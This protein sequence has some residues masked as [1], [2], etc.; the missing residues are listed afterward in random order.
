MCGLLLAA[1]CS[2][3]RPAAAV[4]NAAPEARE[5]AKKDERRGRPLP[6]FDGASLGGDS[7]SLSAMLGRRLLIFGYNPE[8]PEAAQA[9][10]AL[11]AVAGERADHNFEIVG[12]A[13]GVPAEA[14]RAFLAEHKLEIESFHDEPGALMRQLGFRR[15]RYLLLVDAD[16]NML[17]G[18]D[19]FSESAAD[20]AGEIETWA[21]ESLRLP[22][23]NLLEGEKPLA[24][25]FTAPRLRSDE[26]FSLAEHRGK[27][28]LLLTFFLHTCPHCHYALASLRKSL[29][30]LPEDKRPL[31]IGISVENRPYAVRQLLAEEDLDFFPV[32]FD[33]DAK[34][35]TAYGALR[36]VPIIIG[37]NADGRIAWRMEGWNDDRHAALSRMRIAKM[38]GLPISEIPMLLHTTHYSGNEFCGVCHE[39]QTSTWKLTNHAGAYETLLRHGVDHKGECVSCHVVGYGEPGGFAVARPNPD[40]EDV[41]CETCHGRG[42][43][44]RSPDFVKNHDYEAVCKTCHNPEHS[45]GFEYASFLPRVSHAANLAITLL[46]AA[47]RE[48]LL[49][50]RRRP[51]SNLLPTEAALVGSAA[52]RSCHAAEYETWSDHGH[53]KALS[54]LAAKREHRNT[55]CLRCHTTGFGQTG[56]FPKRGTADS[57]PALAGVGCESCHGPGGDHIA[58]EATKRGSIVSLGDKC[59]SCVILQICGSCHDDAN[60]PGFEFEVLDK[61]EAQRHGTIEAGTGR[62]LK[63]GEAK[64]KGAAAPAPKRGAAAHAQHGAAQHPRAATIAANGT[65]LAR[66]LRGSAP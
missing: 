59:D 2:E 23:P 64:H 31:L 20:P 16:G 44:H 46:P 1:G 62:P 40:L 6:S 42:G 25:L 61:I 10:Q 13:M 18:T 51:R 47:Q 37:V 33:P 8:L 48:K 11:A 54:T 12:F 27:K 45:L 63:N 30:A 15:P 9:A 26:T 56:G 21:R 41:G 39:S 34:I 50:E 28:P 7:L 43:P 4:P 38:A 35:R 49:A 17:S 19:Y 22:D 32:V 52:C 58:E 29:E 24:P 60:D 55:D 57:H 65:L 5:S 66:L 36:A 53:A 14:A 3:E